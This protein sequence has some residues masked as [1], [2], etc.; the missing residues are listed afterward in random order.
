MKTKLLIILPVFIIIFLG[1]YILKPDSI[2][3]KE[4]QLT[5]LSSDIQHQINNLKNSNNT[6]YLFLPKNTNKSTKIVYLYFN[7]N[8]NR[9]LYSF[10]TAEISV[11]NNT[12]RIYINEQDALHDSEVKDTLLLEFQA[13]SFPEH[14]E[15]FFQNKRIELKQITY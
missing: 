9:N 8:D 11:N 10:P 7:R 6:S 15:V 4:K 2:D 13:Q 3:S 5:E 12:M 14:I 1:I